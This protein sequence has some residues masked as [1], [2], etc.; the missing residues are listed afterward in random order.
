MIA[1]LIQMMTDALGATT[2]GVLGFVMIVFNTLIWD[3]TLNTGAGG[4]TDLF[5]FMFVMSL[6]LLVL[7]IALSFIKRF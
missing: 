4:F 3:P 1:D 7:G 5:Q 6:V 2:S